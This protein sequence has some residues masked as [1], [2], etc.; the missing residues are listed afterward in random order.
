MLT[1][2]TIRD[3]GV[4]PESAVEFSP[5]LTVL[6]GET[7]AGKTMVVTGLR[8]LVGGRSDPGR[9]REG[10]QKAVVEGHISLDSLPDDSVAAVRATVA[11]AGGEADENDEILLA[12]QVSTKGRSRAWVGGRTSSAAVLA[13]VSGEV[14]AIHG[15]N[16]QLRLLGADEQRAALDRFGGSDHRKLLEK[17][18]STYRSWRDLRKDL[19]ERTEKRRELAMRADQL[20]FAIEEINAVNPEVGE[21]ERLTSAVRRVEDVDTLRDSGRSALDLIDGSETEDTDGASGLLGRAQQLLGGTEDQ[22]LDG[23]EERLATVTTMLSDISVELGQFL[24]SLPDEDE[25]L[26][27]LMNRINDIRGLTRKYAP[28]VEGVLK[29]RDKAS[30]QLDALDVSEDTLTALA[31]AVDTEERNLSRYS[32]KLTRSRE[33]LARELAEQVT[34]ELKGLAMPN[35]S[36]SVSIFSATQF[37]PDGRDVVEFGL[38]A[39][40]GVEPRSL[41]TSAS[42]GELSRV[43]L[44]LEVVLAGGD[45]GRTLVFDEVDAGVGGR[46]AVEIGRRLA[47]LATGNQVIVVTHL[48]QVAAY[49]DSHLHVHKDLGAGGVVSA[50]Q[51]LDRDRRI[52]E[53]ARMMAGLDDTESGRAHASDLFAKAEAEKAEW[54]AQRRT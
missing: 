43:M 19:A 22:V 21:E 42:G 33:K 7:G 41:A 11:E 45:T 27:D 5:G 47:R 3:L 53:L 9:I 54:S 31:E 34:A 29:W 36:L 39:F 10:A 8:L 24:E 6:T 25:S 28:D 40:D 12:R 49:A 15:Q 26:D 13:E 1:D 17:Y 37:G 51:E 52:E 32:K 46:A 16:D 50:V 44:A 30:R 18:R 14:I 38:R 48:P 20:R 4:I 35:T 23:L 2:L